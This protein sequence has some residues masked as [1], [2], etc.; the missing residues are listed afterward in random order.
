[1]AKKNEKAEALSPEQELEAKLQRLEELEAQNAEL[2]ATAEALE[3]LTTEQAEQLAA[4]ERIAPKVMV[5]V[6]G[7]PAYVNGNIR[8]KD[9]GVMTSKEIAADQKL[10]EHLAKI[11]SDTIVF[12]K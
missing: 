3:S 8:S 12:I 4:H 9:G 6:G 1:M 7:K 5:K 11:G 2:K 10:C